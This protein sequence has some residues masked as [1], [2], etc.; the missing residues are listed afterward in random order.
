M[1]EKYEQVKQI[2][3]KY[4]QEHLL[5]FY[6]ELDDPKKNFLLDQILKIDFEQ[7]HT[8]YE[9]S[10]HNEINTDDV[11]SPMPYYIKNKISRVE[12]RMYE[13][14]G[15]YAIR[16]GEFA[17]VTLAGGQGSRLGHSGPKGTFE[18]DLPVKKKSLFEILCDNLKNANT[19][20]DVTIPWYIMTSEA[21]NDA[22]IKFFDDNKYFGY[23]KE[24][25]NFF[26]QEKLPLTDING[27]LFLGEMYMVKDGS[28]GNGN[29]YKALKDNGILQELRDNNIKWVFISGIDNVLI[30]LVDPLFIGL[31]IDT[32][33]EI[34]S[35]SIFKE[36][37]EEGLSVFCLRNGHPSLVHH[38]EI[39]DE[40]NNAKDENGNYY[41]RDA[42]ALCHLF[43][44][45]ALEKCA[46]L[47]LPY[48]R[49]FKKNTFINEEGMK[50]IPE[51]SNS[52][53]F[54]KFI[55]DAFSYFDKMLLL[56]VK[57]EKEFAPIKDLV[58]MNAAT[59]LYI[60]EIKEEAE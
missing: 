35:K 10:K 13:K 44:L 3:K 60:K 2:L 53:K 1:I 43:S 17:V 36:D 45:E 7:I 15:M 37:Y 29:V 55:F 54:E 32:N 22:T 40:M 11:I 52:F 26:Q 39:T 24:S 4:H 58:G 42:N 25:I 30:K 5:N 14:M 47:E 57:K 49:A 18:L 20:Y 48:H 21:N 19:R 8:L 9:N 38:D 59:K 56:R 51:G 6:D 46:K 31:A 23:P 16:N 50:Q 27:N 41:Y 12:A 33:V 28:N 34:G